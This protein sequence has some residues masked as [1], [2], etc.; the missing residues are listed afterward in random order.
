MRN[1]SIWISLSKW[2]MLQ[3]M[4]R[5]FICCMWSILITSMLPAAV[6]KTSPCD[7]LRTL[8]YNTSE[9]PLFRQRLG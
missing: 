5:S 7:N 2:P 9:T 6:T 1:A 3:T 8:G 4:A